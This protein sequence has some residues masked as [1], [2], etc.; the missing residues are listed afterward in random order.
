MLSINGWKM[1]FKRKAVPFTIAS[2]IVKYFRDTFEQNICSL[3]IEN[4]KTLPRE[5][6]QDQSKWKDI[7]CL[8]NRGLVDVRLPQSGL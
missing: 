1:K 5:I 7:A 8:W 3:F 6:K 4:C 2:K